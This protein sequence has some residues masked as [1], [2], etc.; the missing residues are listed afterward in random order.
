MWRASTSL[1]VPDSPLIRTE[2][3]A[4]ATCSARCTVASITWSRTIMVW[5]S[6]DIRLPG[7]R[8]SGRGRAAWQRQEL[9]RAG[10][11]GAHGG[12]GVDIAGAAG[13]DRDRHALRR[14]RGDDGANVMREIAQH[15][16]DMRVGPQPDQRRVRVIRA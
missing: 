16:I 11:D 9:P 10:L 7:S 8:R 2:A 15:K 13:D 12:V 3:S 6:P 5:D 4:R 14:Q 1:P